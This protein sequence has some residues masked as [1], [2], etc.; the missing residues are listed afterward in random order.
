MNHLGGEL[1]VDK[2]IPFLSSQLDMGTCL[3]LAGGANWFVNFWAT[4]TATI[5]TD[6]WVYFGPTQDWLALNFG[7]AVVRV[8]HQLYCN[9]KK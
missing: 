2:I 1:S 7:I 9:T 8:L 4:C 6:I 3:Y 5:H